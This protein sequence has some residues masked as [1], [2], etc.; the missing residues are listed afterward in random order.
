MFASKKVRTALFIAVLLLISVCMY[1]FNQSP[2]KTY[3]DQGGTSYAS[4]EKAKV[5]KV[6][7]EELEKDPANGGLYH[8]SQELE[9]KILS[10]N[11]K[12]KF[13]PLQTI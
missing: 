10:G 13:T 11:I 7:S 2:E 9:I 8:G 4:Y 1:V 6:V 12:V 3:N 5:L